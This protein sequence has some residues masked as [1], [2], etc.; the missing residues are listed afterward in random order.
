MVPKFCVEFLH[1]RGSLLKSLKHLAHKGFIE[2]TMRP[3]GYGGL[4]WNLTNEGYAFFT[5]KVFSHWHYL[6]SKD[7]CIWIRKKAL[8]K[9]PHWSEKHALTWD[10]KSIPSWKWTI[11]TLSIAKIYLFNSF[12]VSNWSKPSK[13][14]KDKVFS[15]WMYQ[16][17]RKETN[18]LKYSLLKYFMKSLKNIFTQSK[19][20]GQILGIKS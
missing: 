9:R 16:K 14:W 13:N 20:P 4:C 7:F 6:E 10:K 2:A 1:K 19:K 11:S 8:Q 12:L 3:L 17:V 15:L 5:I 18:N